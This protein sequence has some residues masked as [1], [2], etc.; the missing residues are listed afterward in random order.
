MSACSSNNYN[1]TL[2]KWLPRHMN[3]NSDRGSR[4]L[5]IIVW[6]RLFISLSVIHFNPE[7]H[8]SMEVVNL[9]VASI[10]TALL[11]PWTPSQSAIY[12]ATSQWNPVNPFPLKYDQHGENHRDKW[13][14]NIAP[15]SEY[16]LHLPVG[17]AAW[18]Y[19][20]RDQRL[21]PFHFQ[22]VQRTA[23]S[24][25]GCLFPQS[26]NIFVEV[27]SRHNMLIKTE[28]SSY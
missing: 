24:K 9:S 14:C 15:I 25:K 2:K 27:L 17:V 13:E 26:M 6:T 18:R 10:N 8:L 3:E 20:A 23:S 11:S 16:L 1:I 21:C 4:D 19:H 28:T 5:K 7:Y 22:L 12:T